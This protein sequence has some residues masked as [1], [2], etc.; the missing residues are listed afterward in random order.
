MQKD[1]TTKRTNHTK[2]KASNRITA[3]RKLTLQ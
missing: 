3:K 1:L 2:P